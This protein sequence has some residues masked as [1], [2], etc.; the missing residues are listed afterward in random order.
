MPLIMVFYPGS[1]YTAVETNDFCEIKVLSVGSA[2]IAS[3]LSN[4]ASG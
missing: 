4:Q 2:A 3:P 1:V